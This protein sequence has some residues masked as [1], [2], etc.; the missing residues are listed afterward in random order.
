MTKNTTATFSFDV[1]TRHE[2]RPRVEY[3]RYV[4]Q[5]TGTIFAHVIADDWDDEIKIKIG[6][7]DATRVFTVLATHDKNQSMFEMFDQ[8][9]DILDVASTILDTDTGDVLPSA[10]KMFGYDWMGNFTIIE[11]FKV[12]NA[13][14]G[15]NISLLVLRDFL[16]FMD[17]GELVVLFPSPLS[18]GDDGK[19]IQATSEE[20]D[21][22]TKKLTKHWKRLGFKKLGKQ[23]FYAV[24]S[25]YQIPKLNIPLEI[26][27]PE[28]VKLS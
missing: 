20:T 19:E 22:A 11:S 15:H 10:D 25:S 13:W 26:D 8:T 21:T 23:G 16:E 18:R 27:L 28:N 17:A 1:A 7:F 4:K 3:S 12:D 9:Q 2:L 6:S 14:R 24:C 5:I